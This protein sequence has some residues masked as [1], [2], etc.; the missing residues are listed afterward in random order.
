MSTFNLDKSPEGS[1]AESLDTAKMEIQI[2]KMHLK[3]FKALDL[4][5]IYKK[6]VES[7]R[8]RLR[9]PQSQIKS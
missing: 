8:A 2:I 9:H 1:C 7:S 3:I 5:K 6:I 4:L